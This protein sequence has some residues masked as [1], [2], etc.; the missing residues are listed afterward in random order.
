MGEL[1]TQAAG[2][3]D[4]AATEGPA[5]RHFDTPVWMPPPR[6]RG[7]LHAAGDLA[8]GSDFGSDLDRTPDRTPGTLA[9]VRATGHAAGRHA[10]TPSV[11]RQS[12]P[13]HD[14]LS[15]TAAPAVASVVPSLRRAPAPRG[16]WRTPAAQPLAPAV[17]RARWVGPRAGRGVLGALMLLALAAAAVAGRDAASTH[18]VRGIERTVL[19]A[20]LAVGLWAVLAASRPMVVDL[21]GS[22]LTVRHRGRVDVFDLADPF[23]RVTVHGV[24]TSPRWKIVLTTLDGR[25]VAV[26]ART[27]DAAALDLALQH[28]RVQAART[29]AGRQERFSR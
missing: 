15:E 21:L 19:C 24:P 25:E 29:L 18:S 27:V 13:T 28:A 11:P 7:G 23:A 12:R 1:P 20:L 10:A 6:P 14:Q 16:R 9:V 8:H 22:R 2:G 17:E 4:L 26:G 3:H 5:A